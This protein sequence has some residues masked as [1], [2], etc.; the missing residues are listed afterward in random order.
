[1]RNGFGV[2]IYENGNVYIGNF[3]KNKKHGDGQFYWFNISPPV[4][5]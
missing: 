2:E 5:K 3:I 1:M 4:K